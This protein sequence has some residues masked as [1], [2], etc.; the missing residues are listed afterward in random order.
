MVTHHRT[1]TILDMTF[2]KGSW[3][4]GLFNVHW[5]ATVVHVMLFC[6][7]YFSLTN[8]KIAIYFDN[9]PVSIDSLI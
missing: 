4:T 6:F 9:M 8:I 1:L 3:D 7:L 2:A 5:F